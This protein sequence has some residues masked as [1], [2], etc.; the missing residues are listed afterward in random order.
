MRDED[1]FK[2]Y[3]Y[4]NNRKFLSDDFRPMVEIKQRYAIVPVFISGKWIWLKSYYSLYSLSAFSFGGH[5]TI[6]YNAVQRGLS[7]FEFK[8]YLKQ[9]ELIQNLLK[10]KRVAEANLKLA[11]Q[12]WQDMVNGYKRSE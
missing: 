8:S 3:R 7:I 5:T 9:E 10:E 2:R 1:C 4:F 6:S 11:P 12:W